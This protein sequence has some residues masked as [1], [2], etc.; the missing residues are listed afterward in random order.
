MLRW[1]SRRL[2]L[3]A[4]S[5][6]G[7]PDSAGVAREPGEDCLALIAAG[8]RARACDP[9]I[10]GLLGELR[11]R[12]D[13]R[14]CRT[15]ARLLL[16]PPDPTQGRVVS[17]YERP[18]VLGEHELTAD[19]RAELLRLPLPG[20]LVLAPDLAPKPGLPA[21]TATLAGAALQ[22]DADGRLRGHMAPGAHT[23]EVRHANGRSQVCVT[24]VAC[25]TLAL[26]AHGASLA[27]HP[28]IRT[29]PCEPLTQ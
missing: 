21:T 19:E 23:L 1:V 16:T 18:P 14:R 25:E 3:A 5:G 4:L 24:L 2:V 10:E 22:V 7:A 28:S 26:T 13:E 29:G 8:E 20:R 11:E 17:V 27:P 12:P 9:A 6:C 15:A